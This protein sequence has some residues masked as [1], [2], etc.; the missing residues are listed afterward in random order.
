[1]RI[2]PLENSLSTVNITIVGLE[3][4]SYMKYH[5]HNMKNDEQDTIFVD[6]HGNI[7]TRMDVKYIVRTNCLND[8][9]HKETKIGYMPLK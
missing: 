1:M 6:H 2:R 3:A 9:S 5:E 7:V 4:K 8:Q